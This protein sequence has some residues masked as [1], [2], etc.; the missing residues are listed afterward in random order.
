MGQKSS[1]IE[2]TANKTGQ[3]IFPVRGEEPLYLV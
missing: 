1:N 3:E 2:D